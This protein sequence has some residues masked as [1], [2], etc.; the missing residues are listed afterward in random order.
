MSLLS[1][2]FMNFLFREKNPQQTVNN[3]LI[4]GTR[5]IHFLLGTVLAFV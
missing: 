2:I 3:C 5:D 1:E 4:H